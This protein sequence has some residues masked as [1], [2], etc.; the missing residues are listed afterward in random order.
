MLNLRS[1]TERTHRLP[2]FWDPI[3]FGLAALYAVVIVVPIYFVVIS[4]FKSNL[5]I[6][7][8]PLALPSHYDLTNFITAFDRA[9]LGEAFANSA[10]IVVGALA[11]STLVG[12]PAAYGIVRLRGKLGGLLEGFFALGLLIPI[13]PLLL[14][15]FLLAAGAGLVG[16]P[17]YIILVYTAI[18]V[19]ITV[20]ILTRFMRQVPSELIESAEIDGAGP[21]AVVRH[22]VLPLVSPGL[23]TILI[24]NFVDLWNEYFFAF[25]LLRT[26]SRT[27]QVAVPSLQTEYFTEFGYLAAGIIVSVIPVYVL[28]VVFQRRIS[29]NIFSGA[30]A[31]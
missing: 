8:D 21:V 14:P 12:L 2:S 26:E 20:L 4:S 10:V 1:S 17:V 6:F 19:P 25:V 16:S 31:S 9:R 13:F 3:A 30:L 24:L 15:V 7:R 28:L 29:E 11:L 23:V 18:R 27:I 22:I 5:E